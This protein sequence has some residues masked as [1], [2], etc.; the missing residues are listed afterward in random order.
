[1]PT[2]VTVRRAPSVPRPRTVQLPR[3]QVIAFLIA[4]GFTSA[5]AAFFEKKVDK[6]ASDNAWS[7]AGAR[8]LISQGARA[9]VQGVRIGLAGVHQSALAMKHGYYTVLCAMIVFTF[10]IMFRTIVLAYIK[11]MSSASFSRATGTVLRSAGSAVTMQTRLL[12]KLVDK[13]IGAVDPFVD[14]LKV[15]LK[16]IQDYQKQMDK[17]NISNVVTRAHYKREI[18]DIKAGMNGDLNRVCQIWVET[19]ETVKS[20]IPAIENTL[21]MTL[22]GASQLVI[23]GGAN[24]SRTGLIKMA[25]NMAGVPAVKKAIVVAASAA[26]GAMGGMAA[27]GMLSLAPAAKKASPRRASPRIKSLSPSPASVSVNNLKRSP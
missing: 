18:E 11:T 24:S 22:T 9:G 23:A 27:S 10:C 19:K 4:S 6:V 21:Q 3:A 5:Q 2:H 16:R 15:Q 7:W 26:G 14:N 12:R 1:M 13:Q 25:Q 17:L 20:A 8:L